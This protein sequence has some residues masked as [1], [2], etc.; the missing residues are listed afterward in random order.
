MWQGQDVTTLTCPHVTLCL[1]MSSHLHTPHCHAP[2]PLHAPPHLSPGP[3]HHMCHIPCF[4]QCSSHRLTLLVLFLFSANFLT[5]H[6]YCQWTYSH[7]LPPGPTMAQPLT[8]IMV[9][10]NAAPRS[11]M[12]PHTV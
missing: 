2:R 10:T 1:I 6:S 9:T 12:T 4:L 3:C 5:H 11:V 7:P 8:T